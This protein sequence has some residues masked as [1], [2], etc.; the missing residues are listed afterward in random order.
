MIIND[1]NNNDD[2][3]H[4][5]WK[6][7][8]MIIMRMIAIMTMILICVLDMSDIKQILIAPSG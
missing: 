8:T 5:G 4:H 7:M 2:D 3:H 6:I 1:N